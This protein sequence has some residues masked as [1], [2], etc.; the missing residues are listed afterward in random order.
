M[1]VDVIPSWIDATSKLTGDKFKKIFIFI[2]INF[3]VAEK[4][5][6]AID[7]PNDI[8]VPISYKIVTKADEIEEEL[9]KQNLMVFPPTGDFE[10]RAVFVRSQNT[11]AVSFI[12][13]IRNSIAH[14]RFNVVR[15]GSDEILVMEDMN[16][17]KECSGRIVVR[18]STL[19]KWIEEI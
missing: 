7:L 8:T 1:K 18:T 2:V 17:K 6:R 14:G 16:R 15:N 19:V 9:I 10:E 4:S 12:D 11:V 5:A 13:H 3:P